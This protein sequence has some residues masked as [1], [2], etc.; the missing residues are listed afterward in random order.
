M[1]SQVKAPPIVPRLAMK[2]GIEV[3][4]RFPAFVDL[5]DFGSLSTAARAG[6]ETIVAK[7]T[8]Q[9]TL[10]GAYGFGYGLEVLAIHP[11]LV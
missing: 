11:S 7:G 3:P 9:A 1:R 8:P 6:C 10:G 5:V 4:A 2:L